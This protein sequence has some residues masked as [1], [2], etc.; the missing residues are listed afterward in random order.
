MR[1]LLV[2]ACQTIVMSESNPPLPHTVQQGG[3]IMLGEYPI[4]FAGEERGKATITQQGMFWYIRCSCRSETQVPCAISVSWT[5]TQSLDLGQ[6]IREGERWCL[7][8]RL[9][10]KNVPECKPVFRMQI[11]HRQDLTKMVPI[12]A[13]QPF[14]YIA[15]LKRAYLV[16][17]DSSFMIAFRDQSEISSPTGQ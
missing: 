1:L 14:A 10:R 5:E 6:C 9:N 13:E 16:Q 3:I 11:R 17:K 4:W 12:C 15:R 7:S 8:V 2:L